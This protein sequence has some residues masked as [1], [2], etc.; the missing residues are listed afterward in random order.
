M[1][2]EHPGATHH[3]TVPDHDPIKI[4]T[5]NNILTD[6]A[7]AV[8]IT[9]CWSTDSSTNPSSADESRCASTTLLLPWS[10]SE[11][12]ASLY[13]MTTSNGSRPV[14]GTCPLGDRRLSIVCLITN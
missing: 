3:L 5:L 2:A 10:C 11:R 4:G 8:G 9:R 7:S 12:A 6:V 14:S 13:R 1:T